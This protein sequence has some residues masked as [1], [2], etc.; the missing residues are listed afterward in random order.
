MKKYV[1][2]PILVENFEDVY[3]LLNLGIDPQ[4]VVID[5][6]NIRE[7]SENEAFDIKQHHEFMIDPTS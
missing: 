7:I 2:V 5:S 6:K 3:D 1:T 4:D